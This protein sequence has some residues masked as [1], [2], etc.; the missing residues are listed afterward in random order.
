MNNAD[1]PPTAP[2]DA[3]R[4]L[5]R[6]RL[7]DQPIGQIFNTITNGKNSMAGY[8]SQIPSMTGGRSP[9]TSRPC[10][11]ARTRRCRT[12]PPISGRS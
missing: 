6:S 7:G 10:S 3:G 11:A 4:N 9:S 8:G 5:H 12:S 1:G 2:V